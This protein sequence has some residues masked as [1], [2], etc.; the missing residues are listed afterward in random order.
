M[1]TDNNVKERKA[2]IYGLIKYGKS[3]PLFLLANKCK[4]VREALVNEGIS[5]TSQRLCSIASKLTHKEGFEDLTNNIK[6]LELLSQEGYYHSELDNNWYT[7]NNTEES[8]QLV[9]KFK[10]NLFKL[11][12]STLEFKCLPDKTFCDNV[13]TALLNRIIGKNPGFVPSKE[14]FKAADESS[15]SK[16]T[17][18]ELTIEGLRLRKIEDCFPAETNDNATKKENMNTNSTIATTTF[19]GNTKD[20]DNT[21]ESEKDSCNNV[22]KCIVS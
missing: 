12:L 22:D 10:I 17:L 11:D 13:A 3:S 16:N 7:M 5:G 8:N 20:M 1:F 9:D 19:F 15:Y 2:F 21:K 4:D 18:I 6:L 14:F